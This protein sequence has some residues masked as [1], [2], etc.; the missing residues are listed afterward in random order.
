METFYF[1][2]LGSIGL[3]HQA[4][5][6]MI[7]GSLM[8]PNHEMS[9]VKGWI[10]RPSSYK[11][12]IHGIYDGTNTFFSIHTLSS[13]SSLEKS[14]TKLFCLECLLLL[15]QCGVEFEQGPRL[16][17]YDHK[18]YTG[19]I[20]HNFND[21]WPQ[22]LLIKWMKDKAQTHLFYWSQRF[23]FSGKAPS[24]STGIIVKLYF[25]LKLAGKKK[26]YNLNLAQERKAKLYH[27]ALSHAMLVAKVIHNTVNL[28][29]YLLRHF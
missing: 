29:R 6:W 23:T 1:H 15:W 7:N 18:I 5:N 16:L 11:S 3:T 2:C 20:K 24:H 19:S 17:C 14:T 12:W 27:S 22:R 4:E 9:F 21:R 26:W 13:F 28:Y 10:L 8:Q 25:S